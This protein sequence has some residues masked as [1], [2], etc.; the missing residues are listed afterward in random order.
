MMPHL[1]PHQF[2][3]IAAVGLVVLIVA[4]TIARSRHSEP[5]VVLAPLEHGDA[6]ALVQELARCRTITSDEAAA[7]ETC[8]RAWAENRRQFFGSVRLPQS[9][10][11]PALSAPATSVKNQDRVLPREVEPQQGEAR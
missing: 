2:A 3:R 8:R 10:I 6:E 5:A 1:T 11:D 9:P 4:L 7:L